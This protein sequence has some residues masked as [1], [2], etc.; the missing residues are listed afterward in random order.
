M[1]G[2]HLSTQYRGLHVLFWSLSSIGE[3]VSNP[4]PVRAYPSF[5]H[6]TTLT[7]TN[8]APQLIELHLRK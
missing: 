2:L 1:E 4:T 5:A 3:I 6:R 8:A 7:T